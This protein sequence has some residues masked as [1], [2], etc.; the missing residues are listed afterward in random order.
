[1]EELSTEEMVACRG[2]Y[3][4]DVKFNKN[5]N[6]DSLGNGIANHSGGIADSFNN[7]NGIVVTLWVDRIERTLF[8]LDWLYPGT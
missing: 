1:M 5:F 3:Y 8:T 6:F 7:T 2:G 4:I